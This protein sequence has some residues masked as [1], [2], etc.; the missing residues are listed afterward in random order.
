M[1]NVPSVRGQAC[2]DTNSNLDDVLGDASGYD[3]AI[4]LANITDATFLL[5]NMSWNEY[6]EEILKYTHRAYVLLNRQNPIPFVPRTNS[7]ISQHVSSGRHPDL[8]AR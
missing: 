4:P 6:T 8:T 7:R 1:P 5:R 3:Y 2:R